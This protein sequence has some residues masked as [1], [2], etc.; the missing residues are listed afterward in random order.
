MRERCCFNIRLVVSLVLVGTCLIVRPVQ[1]RYS[2]GTGEPNDPYR[3]G[4]AEDLNDIGNYVEDYN[5]CF[6]MTA[7]I[8]LADYTGDSFNIIGTSSNHFAGVFDGNGHSISNF[9]GTEGLFERIDEHGV[10][11]NTS[12]IDVNMTGDQPGGMVGA[13]N[14]VISNCSVTGKVT[15]IYCVGGLVGW[16][17]GVV[18]DSSTDCIVNGDDAVGGH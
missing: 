13:N 7:D 14:G 3:I 6:V 2:G 10:V 1:A 15:G 16:S 9:C 18:E 17:I 8:N 11:R 12:L 4:T 5:K